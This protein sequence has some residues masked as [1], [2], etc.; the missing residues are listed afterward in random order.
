VW[1]DPTRSDRIRYRFDG[2]RYVT[3]NV[4]RYG[5]KFLIVEITMTLIN[6]ILLDA[7][8]KFPVELIVSVILA[9]LIYKILDA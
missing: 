3:K 9:E 2:P 1:L 4:F 5:I 7:I 8:S 6:A